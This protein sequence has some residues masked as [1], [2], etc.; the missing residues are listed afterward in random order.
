MGYSKIG[1]IVELR[2]TRPTHDTNSRRDH[3]IPQ[4]APFHDFS[5]I[6]FIFASVP[7]SH[8]RPHSLIDFKIGRSESPFSVSS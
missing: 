8:S 4:R 1:S 5:Q 6:F 7:G 3:Q 2:E